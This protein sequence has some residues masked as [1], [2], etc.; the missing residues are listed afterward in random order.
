MSETD[1]TGLPV[2]GY[3]PQ[4]TKAVEMVNGNKVLEERILQCLDILA[5]DP[6]VDQRWL[7]IGR[8][9][10]EQGF[11]AINRAIFRPQRVRLPSE[12]ELG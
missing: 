5:A 1:L 9:Q 3:Q 11:M 6:A 4:S 12:D 10:L 2:K 7:A 8:T